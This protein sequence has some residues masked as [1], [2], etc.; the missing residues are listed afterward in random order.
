MI[1][2]SQDIL[3]LK[4]LLLVLAAAPTGIYDAVCETIVGVASDLLFRNLV[5]TCRIMISSS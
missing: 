4:L 5:R 2:L 1:A 3:N